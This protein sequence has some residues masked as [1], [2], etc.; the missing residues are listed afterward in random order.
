[1][2]RPMNGIAR[3]PLPAGHIGVAIGDSPVHP[4]AVAVTADGETW[5]ASAQDREQ[6]FAIA[7]AA[8]RGILRTRRL[9]ECA[10][11]AKVT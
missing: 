6:A 2:I 11:R 8:I 5:F 1:M 9:R 7:H 10:K 4:F 3:I